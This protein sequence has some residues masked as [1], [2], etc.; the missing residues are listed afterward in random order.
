MPGGNWPSAS[1]KNLRYSFG[2]N[3]DGISK[4]SLFTSNDRKP[5]LGYSGSGNPT[6]KILFLTFCHLYE[7]NLN[8]GSKLILKKFYRHSIIYF[9][10]LFQELWGEREHLKVDGC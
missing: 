4:E 7:R 3:M 1:Q 9:I 6:Y 5:T 2:R 8:F 10:N